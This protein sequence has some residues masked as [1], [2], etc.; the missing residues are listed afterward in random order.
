MKKWTSVFSYHVPEDRKGKSVRLSDLFRVSR[1]IA[2]GSNA[3]F[4]LDESKIRNLKLTHDFLTP[5]LP[6]SKYVKENIIRGDQQGLPIL[7]KRLFLLNCDIGQDVLEEKYSSLNTYIKRG[8]QRGLPSKYLCSR[9]K[10]WYSQESR[11][12]A[13]IVF[14]YMGRTS[15]QR[16]PFRFIRNHSL[17]TATNVYLMLY[18]TPEFS[19][20]LEVEPQLID[21]VWEVLDRIPF[22]RLKTEGRSY[23]G[24]LHKI[25]P[26]ELGNLLL[27]DERLC[28]AF[29]ADSA[30]AVEKPNPNAVQLPLFCS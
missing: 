9:R 20:I 26:K 8:E 3:F 23:G 13:P 30:D 4:I 7:D 6:S 27:H 19:E 16:S 11:P 10:P 28:R 5:V 15:R 22:S 21:Y 25:E 2:T 1:G 12:P 17:A 24:G 18:P 29:T 14:T